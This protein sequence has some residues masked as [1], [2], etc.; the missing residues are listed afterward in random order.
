VLLALARLRAFAGEPNAAR[1]LYHR[2]R[3]IY[4]DLGG[5]LA[6][7]LVAIDSGP[8]EML[9]GDFDA[10]EAELR[11][12][13]EALARIGERAYLA[14]TAAWLAQVMVQT[15]RVVEA[16]TFSRISEAAALPDDVETQV[17]WRSALGR[18]RALT[19]QRDEAVGL[20]REALAMVERT[21]QPDAQ[22]MVLMDF[23]RV[24]EACGEPA[25]AVALAGRARALFETKGNRVSMAKADELLAN[26]RRP[27]RT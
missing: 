8:V 5:G 18:A 12:D 14:T 26:L 10:A 20:L 3:A 25:K 23:A 17:L 19:G 27:D 4:E 22:G 7:A 15:G 16:E 1:E 2:S 24:Q 11:G 9:A 13:Y 6:A 21:E